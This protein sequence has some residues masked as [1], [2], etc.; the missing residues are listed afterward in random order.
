LQ[1]QKKVKKPSSRLVQGGGLA[2]IIAGVG[3][4]AGG[5]LSMA[6]L[7]ASL[8]VLGAR[9]DYLGT[10]AF[11]IATLGVMGG[12]VGLHARQAGSYGNLGRVGFFMAFVGA[13][14]MFVGQATSTIY[15]GSDIL[16][17]LYENPSYGFQLGI[18]LLLVGLGLLS[19]AT[20]QARVLPRWCG[21]A[22]IGVVIITI[23]GAIVSAGGSFVGVG[24]IWAAL[25][26]TLWSEKVASVQLPQRAQRA[27]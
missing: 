13:V 18:N 23:F 22:L 14:L 9:L 16:E 10:S 8:E 21:L 27:R 5:L 7:Q 19:V 26:Y 3:Y 11:G 12:L 20:V 24:L 17:W 4:V 2:A 1:T 6:H 25:G 15:S